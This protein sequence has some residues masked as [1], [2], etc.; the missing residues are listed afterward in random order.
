MIVQR[1]FDSPI[2]FILKLTD[3]GNTQP[4]PG[5]MIP[6]TRRVARHVF[7]TAHELG[8]RI[9]QCSGGPAGYRSGVIGQFLK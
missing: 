4:R 9:D 3:V 2:R 5:G 1:Q 6:V 7:S 8:A